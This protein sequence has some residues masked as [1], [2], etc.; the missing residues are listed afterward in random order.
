MKN[1]SLILVLILLPINIFAAP[2]DFNN[3]GTSD[4]SAVAPTEDLSWA[5]HI[6][7]VTEILTSAFG[8]LGDH[9]VP[10]KYNSSSTQPAVLKSNFNWRVKTETGVK[11]FTH[12][13]EDVL[14]LGGADFDGDGFTDAAY[15][16]EHC[17][18]KLSTLKILANPLSE[19]PVEYNITGGRGNAYKTYADV[20]NDGRDDYCFTKTSK[21]N[22][23]IQENFDLVCLDAL[24]GVRVD[25]FSIGKVFSTPLRQKT[26]S[27]A[28]NIVTINSK[29]NKVIVNIFNANG[30]NLKRFVFPGTGIVLIG[31]FT[32]TDI[33][34]EQIALANGSI[35]KVYDLESDTFTDVV[36]PNGIHFDDLNI[37]SFKDDPGNNCQ[38]SSR[39]IKLYGRCPSNTGCAI[40][41]D[42]QD[43]TGYGF[44]H[45]PISDTTGSVVN[46][47]P[48]GEIGDG[49][50][51]EDASGQLF[52]ETYF[53][54]IGNG[55]RAHYRPIGGGSCS[56][57][58]A[59]LTFSCS[60]NG[61][62]NCWTMPNPC[63]RYD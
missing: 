16:T 18:R 36:A 7:G 45:K 24:S 56:G 62:R 35:A 55:D 53:S 15:T 12:G 4:I 17:S 51:Y 21:V 14:F 19:N 3:D 59:P 37:V 61:I 11:F 5:S 63:V 22:G 26:A 6:D 43:G 29:A 23:V 27:G 57:F 28:D 8:K 52:R 25:Q 49:C 31:N 58:P 10:G 60:I 33:S 42:I 9:L 41:R 47:L 13:E 38:C 20:N 39:H 40:N 46:L 1:L 32:N 30:K 34:T 50:R 54:S 48:R 2:T 44:L